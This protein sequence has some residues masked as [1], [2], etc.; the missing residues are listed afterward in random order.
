[1]NTEQKTKEKTYSSD[2]ISSFS[3]HSLLMY[4]IRCR[5]LLSLVQVLPDD[6]SFSMERENSTNLIH[7]KVSVSNK[8]KL[9]K[10]HLNICSE[11][12]S[13]LENSVCLVKP[14]LGGTPGT[15]NTQPPSQP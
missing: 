13:W 10:E 4:P 14:G 8:Q 15:T 9:V 2:P 12:K 6:V 3:E 7:V 1:M 5:R 11:C